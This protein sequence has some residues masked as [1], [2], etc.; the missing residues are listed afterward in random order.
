MALTFGFYNSIDHDRRYDAVQVGQIFDGIITD[1]V[2]ET[3]KKALLV[4][5]SAQDNQVIIQ[6][7]RAWFDH[8]WSYNDSD[9]TMSMPAPEGFLDRID[10]VVLDVNSTSNYRRNAFVVVTGAPSGRPSRPT[11]IRELGHNQYPLCYVYRRGGQ[12]HIYQSEI[13]NTVGTSACPFVVGVVEGISIDDL[14]ARWTNEFHAY[15]VSKQSDWNIYQSAME[16][17][18]TQFEIDLEASFFSWMEREEG[19]YNDFLRNNYRAWT[20]WFQNI[21]YELD[22]DV[23]GHL[24]QQIN[25]LAKF[26]YIY[27]VDKVLYLPMSAASVEDKKLIITT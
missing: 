25:E 20:V 23:A 16:N 19:K 8:T 10:A 18:I 6:P 15:M 7:G 14:L 22:G 27:V 2:Y 5:E 1:G 13:T 24:Q 9:Y 11:L 26:T 3:Y 12:N 17:R 4:K 21:Q